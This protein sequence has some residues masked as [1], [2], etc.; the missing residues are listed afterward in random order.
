MTQK[1]RRKKCA[2]I[3]PEFV[4]ESLNSRNLDAVTRETVGS[5][6]RGKMVAAATRQMGNVDIHPP[7]VQLSASANMAQIASKTDKSQPS[8]VENSDLS[9]Y[10][11]LR[12]FR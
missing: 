10:G 2:A 4:S 5:S 9:G 1:T 7:K 3:Q 12:S 8:L 11:Q 6:S